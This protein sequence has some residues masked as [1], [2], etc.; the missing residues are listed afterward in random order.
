MIDIDNTLPVGV[1][2]RDAEDETYD[3]ID[4]AGCKNLRNRL[5]RTAQTLGRPINITRVARFLI[6]AGTSR[7]SVNSLRT[8]LYDIISPNPDFVGIGKG[9]Y[10]YTPIGGG[11]SP[12]LLT[13]GGSED[14]QGSL[15]YG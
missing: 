3:K 11:E 4:L 6:R 13:V 2:T 5:L 8:K 14:K 12:G 9:C 1:A 10:R 7:Q 15:E